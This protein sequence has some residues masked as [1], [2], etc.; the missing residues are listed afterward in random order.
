MTK[1]RIWSYAPGTGHVEGQDLTGFTVDGT[2][3]TLGH[4]DRLADP[5]G[6]SHLVVDTGVWVFG[7]SVLVPVGLVTGIDTEHRTVSLACTKSEV[8][9]APRFRTDSETL[10]PHYLTTVGDYYTNLPPREPTTT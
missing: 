3:G 1:D 8:K 9:Q 5:N 7:R 6:M 4:V 2:D 10:D